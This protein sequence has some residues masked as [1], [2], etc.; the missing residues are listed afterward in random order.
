M[1]A[2]WKSFKFSEFLSLNLR[3]HTL[4][5]TEDANL[6][7][8]RWYGE[9]PFHRELKSALK[10]AKK[11]HFQIRAGDVIYNKLFAWKPAHARHG[12]W[13]AIRVPTVNCC[14]I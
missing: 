12:L 4:G 8:V 10:I 3:P 6:V 2:G 14:D 11:S 1:R 9:G 7:G 5:P 13:K